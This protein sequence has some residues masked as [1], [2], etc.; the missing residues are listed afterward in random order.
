MTEGD[1]DRGHEAAAHLQ[2]AVLELIEAARA[3]LD[4][5]EEAVREPGGVATVITETVAA[6]VSAAKIVPAGGEGAPASTVEHIRIT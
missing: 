5:A 4:V 3:L 1:S 2:R 6:I